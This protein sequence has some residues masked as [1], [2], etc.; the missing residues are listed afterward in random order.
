MNLQPILENEWVHIRPLVK[1]DFDAL[2]AVA[3]DPKIWEQHPCKRYKKVTFDTFF[4][5]SI[6]S[7]AALTIIDKQTGHLIGSSRYK[8]FSNF[9]NVIEIGWTFLSREHWGGLYNSSVKNLMIG[10]A[11]EYVDTIVLFADKGNIRSQKAI[12]K[13][14][15]VVVDTAE[16]PELPKGP[17]NAFIFV[18]K[19]R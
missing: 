18:V 12:K 11:L 7:K 1:E 4:K 8:K 17:A 19:K 9:P 6:S 13:L 10:H 3:K 5:E 16:H 2:F 15:G 14:G